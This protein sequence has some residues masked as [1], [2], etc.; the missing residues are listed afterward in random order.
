MITSFSIQF[1]RV[2]VD[3]IETKSDK[4]ILFEWRQDREDYNIQAK[5]VFYDF[6]INL[7]ILKP[8][9]N[10]III[11]EFFL[12]VDSHFTFCKQSR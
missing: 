2:H 10:Y 8:C 1:F 7:F 11:L 3:K 9:F 6:V 12:C 4:K 5:K